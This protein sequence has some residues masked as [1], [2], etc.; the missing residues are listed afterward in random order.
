[1][2]FYLWVKRTLAPN[3]KVKAPLAATTIG[4]FYTNAR[5]MNPK[6]AGP[7]IDGQVDLV[8]DTGIASVFLYRQ[9]SVNDNPGP[10]DN[11]PDRYDVM[12]YPGYPIGPSDF[13]IGVC[14]HEY[15]YEKNVQTTDNDRSHQNGCAP[16]SFATVDLS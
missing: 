10:E 6:A 12:S 5:S 3:G 7:L 8:V 2:R 4:A 11:A 16:V 9:E 13:W 1:M 15:G 14:D